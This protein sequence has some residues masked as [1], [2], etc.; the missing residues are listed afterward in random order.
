VRVFR[1][2]RPRGPYRCRRSGR[3]D[4]AASADG[5]AGTR[6]APGSR[7]C[8]SP[9]ACRGVT[10]TSFAWGLPWPSA[11]IASGRD[12]KQ[13]PGSRAKTEQA[14]NAG[15]PHTDSGMWPTENTGMRRFAAREGDNC[16]CGRGR[17]Q[18][19]LEPVLQL[20]ELLPTWVGLLLLVLMRLA[21]QVASANR[22]EP[23]TVLPAEDLVGQRECNGVACP[24]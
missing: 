15:R 3:R 14:T 19:L 21:V 4:E 13:V 5:T 8:A 6:R 23:D 12:R 7:A 22:A 9:A 10:W 24:R 17:L 20:R 1:A 16:A 11:S 18:R 2:A